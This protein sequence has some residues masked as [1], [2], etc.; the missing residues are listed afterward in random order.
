MGQGAERPINLL[1]VVACIAS[2]VFWPAG[3]VLA[4]VARERVRESGERGEE[5]V[6]AAL[7]VSGVQAAITA[8]VAVGILLIGLAASR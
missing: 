5:L 6:T 3:L 4:F 7:V 1:A 8:A 2:F